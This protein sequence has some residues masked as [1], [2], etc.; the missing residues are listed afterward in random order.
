MKLD[1]LS[2]ADPSPLHG[3]KRLREPRADTPLVSI[4][5]VVYQE[6]AELP[7][8][9]LNIVERKGPEA[10]IIVVDGGSTDGSVDQ[11]RKFDDQVDYWISEPDAG[12]Y[13]A[14]NKG[15]SLAR[16]HFIFHINA[17]DRIRHIPVPVL[18][19]CLADGVDIACFSVN[20]AGWANIRPAPDS[21]CSL[22]T[23]SV[24]RAFFTAAPATP[25]M[26]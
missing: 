4:I 6:F 5:S 25:V 22:I 12:L 23:P 21:A 9:L 20:V 17:G 10:E 11:L 18:R 7:A 16:G 14:M 15:I 3:G 26:T 2:N 1:P 24:T 19:Q 8:L 13:D